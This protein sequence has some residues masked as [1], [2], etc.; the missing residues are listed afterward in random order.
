MVNRNCCELRHRL[1]LP[2]STTST[3]YRVC[4]AALL[5]MKMDPLSPCPTRKLSSTYVV[6][7]HPY[8]THLLPDMLTTNIS[9]EAL[10][11]K[12]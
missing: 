6:S 10:M 9:D 7:T 8:N 1:L 2:V 4:L 5:V 11:C 3:S 12:R